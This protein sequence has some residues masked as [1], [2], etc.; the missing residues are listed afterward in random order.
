MSRRV[1]LS[2]LRPPYRSILSNDALHD[3]PL[4]RP[5]I[6]LRRL[7]AP[8]TC[9]AST[10]ATPPKGKP[11]VLEQ[12]DKFRP[13]SHPA[14]LNARRVPRSYPGPPLPKAEKEAQATRK[15]PHTFPNEGTRMYWF[16]TN[17]YVHLWITLVY[18]P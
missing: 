9:H 5:P 17:K 3:L 6:F 7:T 1:M 18:L 8:P 13:P 14:R 11:I 12:P 4:R 16:L 15:Y 2:I 10:V